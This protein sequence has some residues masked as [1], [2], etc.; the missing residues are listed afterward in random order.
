MTACNYT[1]SEEDQREARK[2]ML[3]SADPRILTVKTNTIF[4][5]CIFMVTVMFTAE[6]YNFWLKFPRYDKSH[7]LI[8]DL[9]EV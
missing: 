5:F 3:R 1:A 9:L 4:F 8:R 2:R 6:S 7:I